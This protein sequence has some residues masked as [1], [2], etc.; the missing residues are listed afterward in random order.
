[1]NG[2][3][4]Q[5]ITPEELYRLVK[6]MKDEHGADLREI[7]KQTTE[8]N[9]RVRVLETRHDRTDEELQRI[10]SAV[11]PMR[12]I[13][14][15]TRDPDR[16]QVDLSFSPRMWALVMGVTSLFSLFVP[17]LVKVVERWLGL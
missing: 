1:V 9:G 5:G 11:F 10:N 4:R 6:E 2:D 8:T 3:R 13:V 15:P 16:P 17:P 14:S 12:A 7:R